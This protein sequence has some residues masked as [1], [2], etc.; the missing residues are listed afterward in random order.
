MDTF[1]Q[2]YAEC[3]GAV[4]RFIRFR[5]ADPAD[6]EDVMQEVFCAA[7]RVYPTLR[8]KTNARA[9]MIGIARNKCTDWM[10][11]KY[12]RNE[13]T[14]TDEI[15]IAVIPPRFGLTRDSLVRTPSRG[16]G[17]RISRC[18]TCTIGRNFRSRRSPVALGCPSA[19]SRAACTPHASTSA[20][21]SPSE[22]KEIRR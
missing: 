3:R 1:E 22:R 4:E 2:V 12:Q 5:I 17:R 8:D 10:R 20:P 16:F 21:P 11:R 7:V 19:R 9:W 13:I 14:L 18:C 15:R 6:A